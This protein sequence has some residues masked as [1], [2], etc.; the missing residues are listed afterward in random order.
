M[1][2]VFSNIVTIE[3]VAGHQNMIKNI[4]FKEQRL[5]FIKLEKLCLLLLCTDNSQLE[6][7]TYVRLYGVT[8]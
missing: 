5:V 4:C 1:L 8:Q 7:E 2:K 3:V 6:G